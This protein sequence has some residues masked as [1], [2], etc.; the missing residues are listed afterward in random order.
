MR[1]RVRTV[2]LSE[3]IELILAVCGGITTA[4][5]AIS[6][7]VRG[8]STA[9][10]PEKQRRERMNNI[11]KSQKELMD[12]MEETTKRLDR[13]DETNKVELKALLAL[14]NHTLDGDDTSEI[15]QAREDLSTA[16][17]EASS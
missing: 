10:K 13:I 7:L 9:S 11:E 8:F 17:I 16:L 14:V 5:V 6:W 1:V 4:A 15:K 3:I 12:Q 2:S